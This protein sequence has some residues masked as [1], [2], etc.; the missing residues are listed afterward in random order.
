MQ[1]R[2]KARRAQQ[3]R[4]VPVIFVLVDSLREIENP[5][6][7]CQFSTR[8][9]RSARQRGQPV[10]GLTGDLHMACFWP[11]RWLSCPPFDVERREDARCVPFRR[12][13]RS[14]RVHER[15]PPQVQVD[16]EARLHREVA[17]AG[18]RRHVGV[19]VDGGS[20]DLPRRPEAPT[21]SDHPCAPGGAPPQT[22][23]AG[24]VRV[25]EPRAGGVG[26]RPPLRRGSGRGQRGPQ[27]CLR[28]AWPQPRLD[29]PSIGGPGGT[30]PRAHDVIDCTVVR[31]RPAG[32]SRH[33][34]RFSP[35]K[36]DNH[37]RRPTNVRH[38]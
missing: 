25:G 26:V 14:W 16:T 24:P 3:I 22:A 28:R 7:G 30:T 13:D 4:P 37:E 9:K 6:H 35:R 2:R 31:P 11:A 15:A 12:R 5:I 38:A 19:G 1:V 23:G 32:S 21:R 8:L 33:R 36:R 20:T 34:S 18:V 29:C 17:L 10:S 27:S